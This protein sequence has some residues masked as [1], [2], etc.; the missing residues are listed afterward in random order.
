MT[1]NRKS[2]WGGIF[3]FFLESD[4][5]GWYSAKEK[6]AGQWHCKETRRNTG[7]IHSYKLH[8]DT[9]GPWEHNHKSFHTT[10]ISVKSKSNPRL[11]RLFLSNWVL[12]P[13]ILSQNKKLLRQ[14]CRTFDNARQMTVHQ[15]QQLNSGPGSARGG[16]SDFPFAPALLSQHQS[17]RTLGH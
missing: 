5:V 6:R 17:E 1:K 2:G 14:L 3:F 8:I 13:V 15:F 11:S 10:C 16:G 12:D 7:R 9:P 4:F